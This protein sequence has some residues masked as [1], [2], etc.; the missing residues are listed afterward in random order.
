MMVD[1][2]GGVGSGGEAESIQYDRRLYVQRG[3]TTHRH[4]WP[5]EE[6]NQEGGGQR[7]KEHGEEE[8]YRKLD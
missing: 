4:V 5:E 2:R 3:A 6:G 8:L 7:T 1:G